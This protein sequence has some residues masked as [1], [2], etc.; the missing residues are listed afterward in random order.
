MDRTQERTKAEWQAVADG[1]TLR[2]QAFIG[3]QFVDARDG[4]TAATVSPATGRE[5]AQV[6]AC[7]SADVDRAVLSARRAF[8]EGGWS[9]CSA[10]ERKATLL[11]LAALILEHRD[12][13]AVIDS[14]DMGKLVT[15]AWSIDVPGSSAILQFYAETVDKQAGEIPTTPPGN[16]AMV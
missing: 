7:D 12:E 14:L 8:E 15:E 11:R 4:R 13:L 2:T 16:V 10:D 1:L 3:G 6:A 5:L 9:R